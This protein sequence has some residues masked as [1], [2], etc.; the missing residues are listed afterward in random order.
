MTGVAGFQPENDRPDLEELASL[1]EEEF[2]ERFAD[3]PISR[4]RHSGFLRNVAVAMG[5][6]SNG[7]FREVL[8]QLAQSPDGTVREH[9]KWALKR[10]GFRSTPPAGKTG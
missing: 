3:T 2:N 4:S 8:E 10:L 5:N 9:A 7:A 1:S 6:S